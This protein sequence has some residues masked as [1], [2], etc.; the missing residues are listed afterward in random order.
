MDN[1]S[2][3]LSEALR[4]VENAANEAWKAQ[5]IETLRSL[6][7]TQ[8]YIVSDD[9]W[10]AGLPKSGTT[11]TRAL[12]AIFIKAKKEGLIE[13]TD[14]FKTSTQEGCHKMDVRVWRSKVFG[15]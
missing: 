8:E 3:S 14:R 7:R 1:E 13:K 6:A 12:G 15:G 11:E 2:K 10:N 5:A 9:V 4:R